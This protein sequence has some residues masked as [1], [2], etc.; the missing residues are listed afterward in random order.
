MQDASSSLPGLSTTPC[1]CGSAPAESPVPAPRGTIGTPAAAQA[2]STA[3]TWPRSPAGPRPAA[4]GDRR[5]A[6]ALVRLEVLV[7]MQQRRGRQPRANSAISEARSASAKS[8]AYRRSVHGFSW[9]AHGCSIRMALK[10]FTLVRVGPVT[11][12]SPRE[13]NTPWASLSASRARKSIPA[14]RGARQRVRQ[15]QRAGIVFRAV[16]AVGVAGNG[17]DAGMAIQR[18]R[19]AEQEFGLRPPRPLPFTVTVVSPPESSTQ[20]LPAARRGRHRTARCRPARAPLRAPR[21]RWRRPAPAARAPRARQL[22][23]G[24]QRALRRGDDMRLA[25][26]ESRVA[27][28]RRFRRAAGQRMFARRRARRCVALDDFQRVGAGGRIGHGRAGGDGRQ[29]SPGTSEIA[30][31]T[32]RAGAAARARRPPLIAERC[33]RTQLISAMLAPQPAAPWSRR[34]FHRA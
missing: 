8:W 12:R 27:G 15:Q 34:A 19:Q 6:V 4:A 5:T 9:R 18:Q 21:L 16:D 23:G 24:G 32:T 31:V 30:S 14:A 20:G 7:G 13:E 1:G 28:L 25:T 3:M 10:S 29:S 22:R 26:G 2:L 11:T 17:M 33:L